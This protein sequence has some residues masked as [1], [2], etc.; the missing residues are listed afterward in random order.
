VGFKSQQRHWWDFFPSLLHLDW[1]WGPLSLLSSG[2]WGLFPWEQNMKLT[3][4]LLLVTAKVKNAWS[5][6]SIP[7][8]SICLHGM[9]LNLATH[10]CSWNGT[11]LNTGTVIPY[12]FTQREEHILHIFENKGIMKGVGNE[13]HWTIRNFI[14][15][16]RI[17]RTVISWTLWW[18]GPTA[19]LVRTGKKFRILVGTALGQTQ[20]WLNVGWNSR[21]WVSS[22]DPFAFYYQ[23]VR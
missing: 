14:I 18:A 13:W 8:I 16:L 20:V 2:Y 5:C 3:I 7:P 17:V 4:H 12:L 10:M 21:L 15:Y 23:G 9:V 6:T 19:W 1:L 11:K 22:V